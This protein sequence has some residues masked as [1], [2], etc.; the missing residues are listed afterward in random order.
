MIMIENEG[1]IGSG[2]FH[3]ISPE[4]PRKNMEEC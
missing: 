3:N 4:G 1:M 2:Y